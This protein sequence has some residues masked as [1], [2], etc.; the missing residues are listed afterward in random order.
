[1]LSA[2][3]TSHRDWF[4]ATSLAAESIN[5]TSNNPKD[6]HNNDDDVGSED[7]D[8]APILNTT[9]ELGRGNIKSNKGRT[10]F[11]ILI[12]G[13]TGTG[14]T[15][16]LS[17]IAN[18]LAGNK[19]GSYEKF[20]KAAHEAGGGERHSQTNKAYLYCF[21]SRN[22][23]KFNILDTPGLADTRGIAQDEQHK[24]SIARTIKD[25]ITTVDAVLIL[26][27]GTVPRLGVAT[28]YALST[29]SSM[30]PITLA[31]NIGFLFTNVSSPLSWNFDE[32][33]LPEALRDNPLYLLD[34]PVAMQDKYLRE[35]KK[36]ED[37][38]R[39]NQNLLR[40]L[41]ASVEEGHMKA[42]GEL[43]KIVD[44]LD[45]LSSQPT[46][47]ILSL[48]NQSQNIEKR[49]S[50]VLATMEQMATKK[51]ALQ[52]IQR[53]T[54]GTKLTIEQY[55]QYEST[56]E[57]HVYKQTETSKHNTLCAAP[58]CY[59]NCHEGCYLSFSFDPNGLLNCWA[60]GG[61]K[62]THG[63]R[64]CDHSY[65]HHHHYNSRWELC[66]DT[67]VTIDQDAKKKYDDAMSEKE[68]QE[69]GMRQLNDTI[70]NMDIALSES[71]TK[72]G[73]LVEEYARLS[74][75]GSFSGQVKKS[76]SLLELNLET[77]RGN[78]TDEQT[79]KSVEKALARMQEKLKVV[80]KAKRQARQRPS[81]RARLHDAYNTITGH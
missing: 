37:K 16:V 12:V 23:V 6:R 67:Q 52:K 54:D 49:I 69:I 73:L 33:S 5:D 31:K 27:N 36:M 40:T 43:V 41:K 58:K 18:V 26:A 14:K 77:M 76:V 62:G 47:D 60:F 59:S 70:D 72:V 39:I 10:E 66:E 19:P 22:G 8:I 56:I 4:Q 50:D 29:L 28:D 3:E 7:E 21:E 55:K 61:E 75:S 11:T 45:T 1:M 24:E 71:T 32:E 57:Q 63:C 17:L 51:K 9:D 44:W 46:N 15:T 38:H 13:E 81:M 30:F 80:E 78:G 53:E 25:S 34:N 20:N 74:L 65:E 64:Q 35:K 48:Y 42:L 79:I 2:S 68:Q